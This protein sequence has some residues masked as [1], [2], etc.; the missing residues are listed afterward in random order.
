MF[1]HNTTL[2]HV[3][4]RAFI[5]LPVLCF[6]HTHSR[7]CCCCFFVPF[8]V[9]RIDPSVPNMAIVAHASS[10]QCVHPLLRHPRPITR[11][12]AKAQRM[13]GLIADSEEKVTGLHR[14]KSK[15]TKWLER[16]LYA[17]LDVSDIE[18]D[19]EEDQENAQ[20]EKSIEFNSHEDKPL[21]LAQTPSISSEDAVQLPVESKTKIDISFVKR[22]PE[23]L[24]SLRPVSYNPQHLL[25]P[26][27]TA[28]PAT[29]SPN[30]QHQRPTS[31]QSNPHNASRDSFFSSVS[32]DSDVQAVHPRTW[33]VPQEQFQADGRAERSLSYQPPH[34]P[35][36]EGSFA[37][38]GTPQTDE[39]RPRPTS[40][41]TY[42]H[43]DRRNSKIASSRARGLRNNSYPN[44]SRPISVIA[45]RS[46]PGENIESQGI[47]NRFADNEVGPPSPRTPICAALDGF[48][49]SQDKSKDTKK[50]K[51][52][53]SSIPET[54][55]KLAR[56]ASAGTQDAPTDMY[57]NNIRQG[58][59]TQ[60]NLH[61]LEQK[62]C[63]SPATPDNTKP[64]VKLL[65]TP[66][67]SPLDFKHPLFEAALPPPFAPWADVPLSPASSQEK[68][69]DSDMSLSPTRKRNQSRLSVGD[70]EQSRPNSMHSRHSSLG[71]PS[72]TRQIVQPQRMFDPSASPCTGSRRGTPSLERTCIM[73]KTTKDPSAFVNRRISANCWHEASTCFDCL[74]AHVEKCVAAEGWERCT[75]PECG[76]RLTYEDL[77]AFADDDT[78]VRWED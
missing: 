75:C 72:P 3:V 76:E 52:R 11:D 30:M 37:N 66:T 49:I 71:M 34:Q 35:L 33:P 51:K 8:T 77:G 19:K 60:E 22:R 69:R 48:E 78:L 31:M 53:W 45:P 40:F 67:Y 47:C 24:R 13:L 32:T 36:G 25:S 14:E 43:R 55:K 58:N 65:P 70:I 64:G 18:S 5:L 74:R 50:L 20:S 21:V 2:S 12:S 29:M 73:C 10:Q 46:I 63:L 38:L 17:H 23:P 44:Y 6:S 15:T 56:K 26:E 28:S 39:H 16:P 42:Q 57:M 59:L 4:A 7:R 27:W 62:V 54:F 1:A 9:L 68:R 41:V 61:L